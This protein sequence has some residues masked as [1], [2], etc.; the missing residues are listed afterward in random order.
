MDVITLGAAL[1]LAGKQIDEVKKSV[2]TITGP[3]ELKKICENGDA[4]KYF[5]VGDAI[6]IPWTNYTPSTP[7]RYD[8]P[9]VVVDIADCYDDHDQVHH[10]ALW[11]MAQY[12]VPEDMIFDEAEAVSA[13]GTFQDGLHYFTKN[14][15]SYVEDTTVTPGETIGSGYYVHSIGNASILRYGYNNY[16]KSAVRQWLNSDAAKNENWWTAQHDYDVSPSSTYTNKPGWLFGFDEDWLTIFKPVKVQVATNTV[17]DGGLTDVMYDKFFL[18]SV[19][20]IYGS[21]QAE[22]IEGPYWP[23]WKTATG[24]ESPSNGDSSHP[25]DARKIKAI[26]NRKG[27]AVNCRLRSAYRGFAVTTWLVSTGGY[28]GSSYA[29][30]TVRCQPACVIY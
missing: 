12:A 15:D 2:A 30:F 29:Y 22:G 26:A 3:D 4:A 9:F 5:S 1:A 13:S 17:T 7:V 14:G 23:W 18:P 21:P 10:N 20:Q 16:K 28:L 25:N 11:L 24:L 19:E 27:S 8:Y 6:V